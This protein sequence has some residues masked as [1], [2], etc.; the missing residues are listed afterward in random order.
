MYNTILQLCDNF[1]IYALC[2]K[3][4]NRQDALIDLLHCA[5]EAENVCPSMVMTCV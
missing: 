4:L 2:V 3:E 5:T 1:T